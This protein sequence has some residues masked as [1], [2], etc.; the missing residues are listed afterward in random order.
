MRALTA[1]LLLIAAVSAFVAILG[2][3]HI[4]SSGGTTAI[5]YHPASVRISAAVVG[6]AALLGAYGCF[7]KHPLFMRHAKD[8]TFQPLGITRRYD[9]TDLPL[10]S[11]ERRFIAFGIDFIVVII[12]VAVVSLSG[13]AARGS[14]SQDYNLHLDPFHGWALLSL[15]LYFGLGTYLGKGRTLGKKLMRIRVLSLAHD[16]LTLWHSIERS[17]GYGASMLEGGFG[18]LQYF[19]HPN[20]QTVHDHIAET[21]VVYEPKA[22][23]PPIPPPEPTAPSGRRGSP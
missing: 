10:A 8:R 14:G 6:A 2:I 5:T 12:M 18:F 17:L 15:P 1:I 9:L 16:H 13:L 21:I 23:H 22:K 7:K 19:I 4:T 11:F 3:Q 20:S